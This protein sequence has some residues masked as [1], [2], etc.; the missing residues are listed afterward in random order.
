MVN[1]RLWAVLCC[2]AGRTVLGP[3]ADNKGSKLFGKDELAAILR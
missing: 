2:A 1:R 3:A